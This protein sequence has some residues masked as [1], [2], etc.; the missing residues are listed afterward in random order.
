[1]IS[2]TV[3]TFLCLPLLAA[4]LS[5]AEPPRALALRTQQVERI[6][7]FQLRLEAP[8]DLHLPDFDTSRPFS[9]LH[10]RNFARLPQL[11]PADGKTRAVYY[12]Y[13]PG[14]NTLTFLGQA[15]TDGKAKFVLLYPLAAEAEKD[16]LPLAKLVRSPGM[17]ETTLEVDFAAARKVPV[18]AVD[19]DDLHLAADDLRGHWALYQASHLAVL[20]TQVL[21]FNFYSFAREATSRKYGVLANPWVKRQLADPEHRLYEITTGADAIAETL[22]LHRLL[23]PEARD[24]GERTIDVEKLRGIEV[25]EQ[26]FEKMLDGKKP[27]VEP[28]ARLVPRDNYYLHFKSVRKFIEAGELFDE[29]GTTVNRAY[30]V[31]S[32]DYQLRERYEKQLCLKSTALGKALGPVLV[33]GLAVTGS[34]PFLREG[35]DIALLFQV[36]DQALFLNA[37]DGFLKEARATHRGELREGKD[38]YRKVTIESFVTPLREV[39][40]YRA[41]LDDVVVYANSPAGIRRIIDTHQGLLTAVAGA[42]DFRYMRTVF[43]LNEK[44]EEG[45]VFLSDTFIRRLVGP[46]SRIKERRR[47]EAL[48]SLQMLTNAALFHAWETGKLPADHAAAL[49]GAGLKPADV[50]IPDGKVAWDAKRWLAISDV[51][52]TLHFATPL[53][54]L[55]IDKVTA[56]EQREYG[57]FRDE[58]L[59][60][61]TG[62]FDPIALRLA[63]DAKRI[64]VETH[65][66]PV[67]GSGVYRT[68]AAIKAAKV[69]VKA[70]PAHVA[71]FALPVDGQL[72][73]VTFHVDED[74]L[75]REVIE[76]LIRWEADPGSNPQ[77]EYERRFWNLPL[78]LGLHTKQA[79]DFPVPDLVPQIHQFLGEGEIK[80]SR[81]KG[82]EIAE[83][84]I[85]AEKYR[86]IIGF[87]AAA[88]ELKEGA[89]GAV[90]GLLPTK[91]APRAL[92]VATFGPSLYISPN[93]D[94]VRKLIA[95]SQEKKEERDREQDDEQEITMR[96]TLRPEKARQAAGLLFEYEDHCLTLLNNEVWNC[97]YKAGILAADAPEKERLATVRQFLGYLPVS[98]TGSDYSFDARTGEVVNRRH[99]SYR[100]PLLHR[101]VESDSDLGRFLDRLRSVRAE[102]RFQDNGIRAWLTIERK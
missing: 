64:R 39:S 80:K 66:L 18:P 91:E 86:Q 79:K 81:H 76:S 5:A 38:E 68:L 49:A 60:L 83:V 88:P 22:Q 19:P 26:P 67:A 14:Q 47:L 2:R 10:R 69:P 37:V 101:D 63:F 25:P 8:A 34:D 102:L 82:V 94:A 58:Y 24:R 13:K 27:A 3:L 62:Y 59:K 9:E 98:P 85:A 46:A 93:I 55:P 52:N 65:I 99:G 73:W 31:R 50:A 75:L 53:I 42:A 61:W 7:Y 74:V 17:A 72:G 56:Q 21:D 35:S 6:T 96:L 40:L 33:K 32:R 11:A 23:H 20:E 30:E 70:L 44:E 51:Y 95:Q 100:Q 97:F 16:T 71:E 57:W 43:A 4:S 41:S 78:A 36:T 1:M 92:F 87:V 89:L 84:P 90:V 54:E 29:W 77:Q 48:T 45:F 15:L 28:L 12:R